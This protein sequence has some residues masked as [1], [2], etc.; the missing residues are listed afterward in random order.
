[1]V[2]F[3]MKLI[4]AICLLP[5]TNGARKT[6][7]RNKKDYG[8]VASPVLIAEPAPV[9]AVGDP[10]YVGQPA[11][12]MAVAEP[13]YDPAPVLSAVAPDYKPDY[14][15]PAPVL[16]VAEPGYAAAPIA[17]I[18]SVEVLDLEY[19]CG[20]YSK[21]LGILAF[22]AFVYIIIVGLVAVSISLSIACIL[23]Y[24]VAKKDGVK[25]PFFTTKG[26]EAFAGKK[27]ADGA[28]ASTAQLY[29]S[30]AWDYSLLASYTAIP[31]T[32]KDYT[33]TPK[34][35]AGDGEDAT[36]CGFADLPESNGMAVTVLGMTPGFLLGSFDIFQ[37]VMWGL[38]GFYIA[39]LVFSWGCHNHASFCWVDGK[40]GDF[41]RA[42]TSSLPFQSLHCEPLWMYLNWISFMLA[43]GIG[44]GSIYLYFT[45]ARAPPA[46]K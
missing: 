19:C 5:S 35:I 36:A 31:S 17:P 43:L 32:P 29:K 15:E 37:Y 18:L 33:V 45:E 38:L 41:C 12:V 39:V 28:A 3:T 14:A 13:N 30:G 6:L 10:G 24:N 7:L 46:K 42:A 34:K 11:P 8:S 26:F 40:C 16:A 25:Y 1:M 20:G 2:S 9:L 21:I 27:P 23:K 22:V 4:V 44:V